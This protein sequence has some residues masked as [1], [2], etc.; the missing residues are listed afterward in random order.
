MHT[1]NSESHAH[2]ANCSTDKKKSPAGLIFTGFMFIGM[3]VGFLLGQ[4]L[5]GLFIGMGAGF[6]TM[7]I[8]NVN[9]KRANSME[10]HF[11]E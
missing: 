9:A 5:P 7:A 8:I 11:V 2:Q 6:I 4:F 1:V 3:G 10:D